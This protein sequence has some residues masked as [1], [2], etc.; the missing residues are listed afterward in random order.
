MGALT[1]ARLSTA[2]AGG[3]SPAR[4]GDLGTLGRR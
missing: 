4:N 1:L 2:Y 3:A